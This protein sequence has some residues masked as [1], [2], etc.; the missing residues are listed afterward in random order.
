MFDNTGEAVVS[1][2]SILKF[3]LFPEREF[4]FLSRAC[5]SFAI[6][7]NCCIIYRRRPTDFWI[8]TRDHGSGICNL[9]PL[10]IRAL[11]KNFIYGR[12]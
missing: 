11:L 4:G 9:V 1:A 5:G 6:I 10:Q 7:H 12:K 2:A 8:E 3:R